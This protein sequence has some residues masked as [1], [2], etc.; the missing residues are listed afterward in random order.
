MKASCALLVVHLEF[1]VLG[2]HIT[3][4]T[5][6]A[7]ATMRDAM[8]PVDPA[9]VHSTL[10][11]QGQTEG[12]V[13]INSVFPIVSTRR[14]TQLLEFYVEVLG[15]RLAYRFPDEGPPQYVSIQLGDSRLGVA[16]VPHLDAIGTQRVS[17]WVYVDDCN[18]AVDVIRRSGGNVLEEPSDQAWGERIARASDPDGNE[19]VVGSALD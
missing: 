11:I 2:R 12:V 1:A 17:L 16:E 15:G 6:F 18:T 3:V 7:S 14:L 19:I 13:S 4:L 10:Q 5:V 9:G 8:R